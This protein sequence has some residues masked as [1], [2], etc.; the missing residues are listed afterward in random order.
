MTEEIWRPVV[1]YEGLYEVSSYGRVRSLD[2]Y[3]RCKSYK[4][5]KG[6]VLSPIITTYGY[7]SVGL[8]GRRF[9]IHR[10]VAQA[11]LPNPDNLPCVN[12]RNEDKTDNRV[13]NLEWCTQQY[14]NTYGTA[15]IRT[16]DTA[17]KNGYWRGLSK[18]EYDRKYRNEH[19]DHLNECRRENYQENKEKIREYAHRY[20][21]E[22]K[23]KINEMRRKYRRK[24]KAGLW[25][26]FFIID[27]QNI[28]KIYII[29]SRLSL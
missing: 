18:K 6:K 12:H 11:F 2:R 5:H 27:K 16:R 26:A 23:D 28:K 20:Y 21:Q 1:G 7:L 3:V 22:N 13:D 10:L 4:L 24:K 17:I 29:K 14:N 25:P 19:R 9:S 15:R 8:Q